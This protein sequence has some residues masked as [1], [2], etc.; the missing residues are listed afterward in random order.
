MQILNKNF[1]FSEY[2]SGNHLNIWFKTKSKH[3]L[4]SKYDNFFLNEIKKAL[5]LINFYA[6][7][8]HICFFK[9]ELKFNTHFF[10]SFFTWIYST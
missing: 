3:F 2:S 7:N 8:I 5:K 6:N 1:D 9:V 4:L 10:D